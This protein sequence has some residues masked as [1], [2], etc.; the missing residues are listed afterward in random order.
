MGFPLVMYLSRSKTVSIWPELG[1]KDAESGWQGIKSSLNLSLSPKFDIG[2]E[3]KKRKDQPAPMRDG[4]MPWPPYKALEIAIAIE[5][6]LRKSRSVGTMA[7]FLTG[8][9]AYPTYKLSGLLKLDN[10]EFSFRSPVPMK[11]HGLTGKLCL[12]ESDRQVSLTLALEN[13]A[14]ID[15]QDGQWNVWE[16]GAIWFL[17]GAS[18]EEAIRLQG[19]LRT[20]EMATAA[21]PHAVQFTS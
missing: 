19:C 4:N 8:A 2:A 9:F 10:K 3:W 7:E 20:K 1:R 15:F 14:G 16:S 13:I 18:S 12:A 5:N 17:E 6:L 11:V 21:S